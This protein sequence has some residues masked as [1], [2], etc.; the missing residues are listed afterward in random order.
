MLVLT[1]IHSW[2]IGE[3]PLKSEV[4]KKYPSVAMVEHNPWGPRSR[5]DWF[6]DHWIPKDTGQQ[7]LK[8]VI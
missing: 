2:S 6:M 5:M 3:E 1:L 7:Q 4:A 8:G